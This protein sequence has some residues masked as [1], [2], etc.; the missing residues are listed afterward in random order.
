M[1]GG[2]SPACLSPAKLFPRFFPSS[3]PFT[4]RAALFV[5][6]WH[7]VGQVAGPEGQP[8]CSQTHLQPPHAPVQV[9]ALL[10]TKRK[11]SMN[12]RESFC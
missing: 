10:T 7:G 3:H 8:C 9:T 5:S 6:V 2:I 11:D 12:D 4:H 1:N